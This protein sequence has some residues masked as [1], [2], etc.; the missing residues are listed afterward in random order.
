MIKH[1]IY[2]AIFLSYFFN[3]KAQTNLVPNPSFEIHHT[4]PN[5]ASQLNYAIPWFAPSAGTPD[6]YDTCAPLPPLSY[7]GIPNTQVGYCYAHSGHGMAG[8]ILMDGEGFTVDTFY[9]REYLMVK[10][11]NTLVNHQKYY[12]TY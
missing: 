5:N 3:I 12:L 6:L 8:I 9:Y 2:I 7:V 11:Q 10:L 1:F 4:C